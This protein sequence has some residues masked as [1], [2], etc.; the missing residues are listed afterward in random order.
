MCYRIVCLKCNKPTY[1]GCGRHIE[2]VL[3]DVPVEER[4]QCNAEDD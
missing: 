2:D 4:C 1:R 3:G